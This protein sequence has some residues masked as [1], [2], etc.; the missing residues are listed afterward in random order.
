MSEINQSRFISMGMLFLLACCYG[1]L[2][3]AEF[4]NFDDYSYVLQNDYVR[5]GFTFK[6]L[7]WAF[8]PSSFELA[9]WHPL[10]MLSH[11]LDYRLFGTN[12]AGHHLTNIVIHAGNTLLLFLALRMMTGAIWRSA[13]VTFLFALH[14]LHVESVAWISE[15]KDML[16]TFFMV[17][18]LIA[19]IQYSKGKKLSAY[20]A[21]V[22]LYALSL[23]SKPMT[24]TFPFLLM[25][26]DYWPLERFRFGE[27]KS[28]R[29]LE[30]RRIIYS[31]IK[32]KIPF[33]LMSMGLCVVTYIAQAQAGAVSPLHALPLSLR[34][35][36]AINSYLQ[37]IIK[38]LFP[39]NLSIF[40]P[41]TGA[42]PFLQVMGSA[43]V[44]VLCSYLAWRFR[45]RSPFIAVGWGWYLGS[46][47]PVIGIVQVGM[48]SMADRYTYLP[49][50]GLFILFVWLFPD[51]SKLSRKKQVFMTLTLFSVAGVILS[52]THFQ[53]STW[54][55]T[56][57]VFSRAAEVTDRNILAMLQTAS[58]YAEMGKQREAKKT[59]EEVL[60]IMPT[61][62]TA[63]HN[64]GVFLASTGNDEEG[65]RHLRE[66]LR[67]QPNSVRV[68]NS[69]ARILW[70]KGDIT[71]AERLL[72]TS[73][74]VKPK[75]PDTH[76]YLAVVRGSSPQ[77][78]EDSKFHYQE[79]IRLK[80]DYYRAHL[81]LAAVLW[82]EGKKGEAEKH[83][84]I[85][86]ENN[87]YLIAENCFDV[88]RELAARNNLQE[89]ITHYEKG[90]AISPQSLDARLFLAKLY[91]RQSNHEA[92]L[93]QYKEILRNKPDHMD[94]CLGIGE[95]MVATGKTFEAV[96]YFNRVLQRDSENAPAHARLGDIAYQELK[97]NEALQHYKAAIL[98]D[99]KNVEA[100]YGLG[101]S[102][103]AKGE[104]SKAVANLKLALKMCPDHKGAKEAL[105]RLNKQMTG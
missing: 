91:Q 15:R 95:V 19:Y 82:S 63:H 67:L 102:L 73:L 89:A 18:S 88:G 52:A 21:A 7:Y 14:P 22:F 101:K 96:S 57:S 36:N 50:I 84:R 74:T 49:M 45:N 8:F 47:I 54:T 92:A 13:A 104:I 35:A 16:T 10:T 87:P 83:Y 56:M 98:A 51:I 42:I 69:L 31:L 39:Y 41:L 38:M 68:H 58:Q 6:S 3:H 100:R 80:P 105:I 30:N 43:C 12:A 4:I 99:G 72:K 81:G 60:A 53:V 17:L 46:L 25:L 59:F 66:A 20:L 70:S 26:L 32:E 79:T 94:A 40:Y 28:I 48:Q 85:V 90:I 76:Y 62:V 24:V 23:M 29:E 103:E 1:P 86:S 64:Y 34:F 55:S 44:L 93:T 78:R 37:Y 27:T 5:E 65:A 33:L 77:G 9:N 11:M 75:D 97:I 71:E 2:Y 61:N